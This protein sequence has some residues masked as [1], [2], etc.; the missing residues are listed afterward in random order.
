MNMERKSK[1]GGGGS[2]KG[3]SQHQDR[4]PKHTVNGT[5]AGSVTLRGPEMNNNSCFLHQA[6][7]TNT[8]PF[9][10]KCSI[11]NY[12]GIQETVLFG[13]KNKGIFLVEE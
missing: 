5:K 9:A 10:G 13:N 11:K 1:V 4:H 8:S 6:S 2:R 12:T 3:N 7:I